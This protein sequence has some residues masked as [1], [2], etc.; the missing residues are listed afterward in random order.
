MKVSNEYEHDFAELK[1]LLAIVAA[2]VMLCVTIVV[3]R[4]MM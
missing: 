4:V 2:A 1:Q 3:S